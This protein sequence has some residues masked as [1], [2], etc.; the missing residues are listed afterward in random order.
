[1]LIIGE[2]LNSS[3]LQTREA[4]VAKDEAAV[5]EL[6]VS[7]VAAG[8][9][10]LD[11]NTALTDDESGMMQ[12]VISLVIANS[13]VGIMIDSQNVLV[14]EAALQACAGQKAIINSVMPGKQYEPLM[15]LAVKYGCGLV[16]MPGLLPSATKTVEVIENLCRRASAM[17]VRER[18]L[19]LDA[20]AA[21]VSTDDQAGVRLLAVISTLKERYPQAHVICGISNISYGMP[22]RSALNT[23]MLAMTATAGLDSVIMDPTDPRMQEM[24]AAVKLLGGKDSYGLEYIQKMREEV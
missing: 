16:C 7:Q 24:L 13:D 21:A 8:A 17:G 23:A 1:M 11:I 18:Y 3:V 15:E 10:Y 4:F 14:V 12:W 20:V 6:I 2:K 5:V 9:Q 22:N 19:Y